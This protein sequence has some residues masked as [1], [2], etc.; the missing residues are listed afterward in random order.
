MAG[1]SKCEKRTHIIVT[2][3]GKFRSQNQGHMIYKDLHEYCRVFQGR[4]QYFTLGNRCFGHLPV[5]ECLPDEVKM[6]ARS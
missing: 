6:Y 5:I 3:N 1:L 4:T 2:K